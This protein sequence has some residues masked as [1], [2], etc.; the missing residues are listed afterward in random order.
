MM[1][2]IKQE[3]VEHTVKHNAFISMLLYQFIFNKISIKKEYSESKK[4][5]I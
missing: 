1:K 3:C 4:E 2:E 5:F